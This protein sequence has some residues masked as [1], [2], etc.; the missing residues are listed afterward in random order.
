MAI[1]RTEPDRAVLLHAEAFPSGRYPL[2]QAGGKLPR[3]GPVGV[4]APVAAGLGAYGLIPYDEAPRERFEE[5]RLRLNELISARP[6]MTAIGIA[7]HSPD[8]QKW[9]RK[10]NSHIG[11]E[12]SFRKSWMPAGVE[13]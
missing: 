12:P 6:T 11:R 9:R 5:E 10:P 3:H 8:V 7:A 1:S 13:A 2:R 4:N